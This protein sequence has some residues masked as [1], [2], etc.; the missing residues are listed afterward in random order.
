M[1]KCFRL[2]FFLAIFASV[3]VRS[4]VRPVDI[5]EKLMIENKDLRYF[6]AMGN[7]RDGIRSM[8]AAVFVIAALLLFP[9]VSK[10]QNN[11]YKINDELYK[12]YVEAYNSRT[13]RSGVVRSEVM[14]K[15][16][17]AVGDKK[18]QCLA[19]TIPMLYASSCGNEEELEKKIKILQDKALQTG[20]VQYYYYGTR[21]KMNFLLKK[22]KVADALQYLTKVQQFAKT[23][24]HLYGIYSGYRNV[25]TV[26]FKRG[27]VYQALNNYKSA[28]DFGRE[29]LKDQDMAQNYRGIADCYY[30]LGEY[31]DMYDNLKKG[32][33][34]SKSKQSRNFIVMRM[35]VALFMLGRINEFYDCYDEALA[36]SMK[37]A[38][39]DNSEYDRLCALKCIAD[40]NFERARI[41]IEQIR[42]DVER[43]RM[44]SVYYE[45]LGNLK[46]VIEY[47]HK[48][49]IKN[50]IN[51]ENVSTKDVVIM[52][53]RY[54]ILE[55]EHEKHVEAY[56]NAKLS[57]DNTRLSLKNSELELGQTKTAEHLARLS[58]DNYKLSYNNKWLEAK[59]LRDSLEAQKRSRAVS[60]KQMTLMVR[61]LAVMLVMAIAIIVL[62]YWSKYKS[63]KYKRKL[64][65]AN[66]VLRDTV[67]KLFVARDKALNADRMKTMFL[68]NM[69]H[70]IRTPLN[71]IVG[72]SQLLTQ[73]GDSFSDEEK[74]DMMKSINDNTELLTTLIDDILDITSLESGKYAM[75]YED[76][77]VNGLC[78]SVLK[79]VAHR[80]VPGVELRLDMSIPNPFHVHTDDKRVKQVLINF[81]TNAAKNTEKG[82]ITLACSQD[83]DREMLVF[84]VTDTGIGVPKD[85]MKAIFERFNKLD[86]YKQG[87]GL[88]LSI[89]QTIA[90][91]LEGKIYIDENYT[92]GARFYFEMKIK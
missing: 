25:A 38:D 23:H 75:K 44:F 26:H 5:W 29:Y 10:A 79:T 83:F 71:A 64:Q 89:C 77:E 69:S 18:A 70:E 22:N 76:V 21:I 36:I 84:S 50:Y 41:H 24:N 45:K 85:K 1:A 30:I 74:E 68:Q 72:F 65:K 6:C 55:M 14:Y 58:A 73:M 39:S 37:I 51:V 48:I 82:C 7:V 87:T 62:I 4:G 15:K 42:S 90:E 67:E 66:S 57:L 88:G 40:G 59:R 54:K 17:V 86:R 78:D 9:L 81:L 16:A 12:I 34:V 49:L 19:L 13:S 91:K 11:P 47:Q 3:L 2:C 43:Y 80:V 8:I 31:E 56:R 53:E 46:K 28:L 33:S 61:V 63:R 92:G 27:E 32:L 60:E 52:N 35:P 20:F